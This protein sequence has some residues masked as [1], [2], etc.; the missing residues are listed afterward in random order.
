MRTLEVKRPQERQQFED[1]IERRLK[2]LDKLFAGSVDAP[3]LGVLR[4]EDSIREALDELAAKEA[5]LRWFLR[6]A[7]HSQGA[8]RCK[9]WLQIARAL[10]EFE[11]IGKGIMDP[12]SST[13]AMAPAE[14]P[15]G[16]PPTRREHPAVEA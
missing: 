3:Y 7:K 15:G 12:E 9:L 10:N 16:M 8:V 4:E 14:L 6:T 5:T 13:E 1:R 11:K 2:D